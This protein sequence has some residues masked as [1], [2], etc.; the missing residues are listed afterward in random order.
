MARILVIDDDNLLRRMIAQILKK[1]GHEVS[2]ASDGDVG[3]NLFLQKPTDL[4][5]TDMIMPNKEGLETIK[6]MLR[7]HPAAKIIAMSAGG[8]ISSPSYL[9]LAEKFGAFRTFEKGQGGER[10]LKLIEEALN[11]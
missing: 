1:A 7:F 10:L 8:K 5:L 6:E 2:E 4:V 9:K 11:A 3:L